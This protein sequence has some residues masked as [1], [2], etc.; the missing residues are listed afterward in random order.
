M[1]TGN[2]TDPI[3]HDEEAARQH[4]EAQ[5]WP[6]GVICPFCGS[7]D[8]ARPLAGKSMGPGWYY[9]GACKDKFTVRTK[10][11]MERSHIPL[12]KWALGFR[13]MASSKK[14]IS[15][16]QLFRQL[17]FGSYRTAWFMAMRIREAMKESDPA[18]LGGEGKIVEADETFSGPNQR[19]WNG[20]GWKKKRGATSKRDSIMG[21]V[22]RGGRARLFRLPNTTIC[23]LRKVLEANV[24]PASTLHTDQAP[25]YKTLGKAFAGHES[26]NHSEDEFA[27]GSVTTNSAEG[28]FSIFKRG[29]V[30]VYQHCGQQHLQRYLTEFEFRYSHRSALGIE[31][32]ERT[33][34]AIKGAAGKRLRYRRPN[35]DAA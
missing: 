19:V 5:R 31:D 22:E 11:V 12:H 35:R 34:R 20:K 28:F 9:C 24:D 13:L 23:E 3:F 14:G 8:G 33:D 32:A 27:R 2:L 10:S 6:D 15:A 26:V 4:F 21:L 30:G 29:M 17:G 18:P 16:H 25:A 1:T 7:T